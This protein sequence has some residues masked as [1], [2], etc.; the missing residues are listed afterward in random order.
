MEFLF[1]LPNPYSAFDKDGH[2]CGVCPRDPDADAGGPGQFVGARVDSDKTEVLQNFGKNAPHELRSPM[3]STKYSYLGVAS[4]DLE[5]ATKLSDKDPIRLPCTRYYRDRLVEG[6]ILAA[7]SQTAKLASV[8]HFVAAKAHLARYAPALL[9]VSPDADG[10]VLTAP[11]L[12]DGQ[13]RE[14]VELIGNWK[15]VGDITAL[16][17]E[18]AGAAIELSASEPTATTRRKAGN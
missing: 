2:P 17:E 4:D 1:V 3:Q 12:L 16:A 18:T 8:P 15:V 7:D 9:P 13:T 14:G 11:A 5:L 6:S 10:N